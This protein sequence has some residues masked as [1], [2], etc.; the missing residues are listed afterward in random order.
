MDGKPAEPE[1][2]R[3]EDVERSL[4]TDL[5]RSKDND[6]QE[7]NDSTS[8]LSNSIGGSSHAGT[9]IEVQT[10]ASDCIKQRASSGASNSINST[11]VVPVLNLEELMT[12]VQS[13]ANICVLPQAPQ[14]ATGSSSNSLPNSSRDLQS[15]RSLPRQSNQE[16]EDSLGSISIMH[17]AGNE[18]S[19]RSS[20]RTCDASQ[21]CDSSTQANTLVHTQVAEGEALPLAIELSRQPDQIFVIIVS[22]DN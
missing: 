18:V 10:I 13:E 2:K 14:K 15:G 6:A 9:S 21:Q 16:R 17:D 7:A 1:K 19:P 4:R 5:T 11:V 22:G 20:S 8:T 12:N 3:M